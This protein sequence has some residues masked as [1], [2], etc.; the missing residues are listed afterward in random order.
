MTNLT[1]PMVFLDDLLNKG[2]EI[3]ARAGR[4][5]RRSEANRPRARTPRTTNQTDWNMDMDRNNGNKLP[6]QGSRTPSGRRASL[7]VPEV[8][9]S[10]SSKGLS[11]VLPTGTED[12]QATVASYPELDKGPPD[13]VFVDCSS[14]AVFEDIGSEKSEPEHS[15]LRSA[16]SKSKRKAKYSPGDKLFS[17][18]DEDGYD[19][20]LDETKEN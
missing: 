12:K 1:I 6:S 18:E 20:A 14:P 10:S 19:R 9:P 5:R 15:T 8:Y 17:D 2:T 11:P 7:T 13:Q 4:T 16:E 3:L